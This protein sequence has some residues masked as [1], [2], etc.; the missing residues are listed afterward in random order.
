MAHGQ[1]QDLNA[2]SPVL[3]PHLNPSTVL[4]Q[5]A[6]G[7]SPWWS[8]WG[9]HCPTHRK[10]TE[11][12]LPCHLSQLRSGQSWGF[13]SGSTLSLHPAHLQAVPALHRDRLPS[14]HALCEPTYV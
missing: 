10:D 12:L 4:T 1:S 3:S 2:G 11:P 9:P 7:P 13:L 14:G 5:E 8:G 6:L